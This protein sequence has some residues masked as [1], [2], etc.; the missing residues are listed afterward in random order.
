MEIS[1][2]NH[3]KLNVPMALAYHSYVPSP[4]KV[5]RIFTKG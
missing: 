2:M 1:Q 4:A 3:G 5:N